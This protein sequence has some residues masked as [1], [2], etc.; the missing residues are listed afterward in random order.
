MPR[1]PLARSLARCLA[2]VPQHP[3]RAR[4][5][6]HALR[7]AGRC[8][9]R[10]R[11]VHPR[12]YAT[13]AAGQR[14]AMKAATLRECGRRCV[15]CAVALGLDSL[16][17]DHV[18]P[19]SKGGPNIAGNVVAACGPCNRLKADLLPS[20]FF[21]LHPWAGL[22]FVRYARFVHRTLKRGARRAVSLACAAESAEHWVE[23]RAPQLRAA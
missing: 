3:N 7:K 17:L 9:D 19:R 20:E 22:N 4:F 8:V 16:T 13:L 1:Q 21:L 5:A 18:Y 10:T 2:L 15:Y 6:R 11:A 23:R 14:R 12:D